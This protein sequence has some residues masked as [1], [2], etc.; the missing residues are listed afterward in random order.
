[1]ANE[2]MLTSAQRLAALRHHEG[3][4]MRHYNDAA[5]SCTFGVSTRL[6]HGRCTDEEM[7]R[8]VTKVDVNRQL[9]AR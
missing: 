7:A 5:G 2:N 3:A 8:P 6:H 4:V 1:M 9:A